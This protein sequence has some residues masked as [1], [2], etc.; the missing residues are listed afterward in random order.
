MG[1]INNSVLPWKQKPLKPT[2]TWLA[3]MDKRIDSSTETEI[4]NIGNKKCY[5]CTCSCRLPKNLRTPK[6]AL[7]KCNDDQ[8]GKLKES[9]ELVVEAKGLQRKKTN[10]KLKKTVVK[11]SIDKSN[12][13]TLDSTI[14][15]ST[16]PN[17]VS[18]DPVPET[19]LSDTKTPVFSQPLTDRSAVV[20]EICNLPKPSL[21][22]AHHEK[23]DSLFAF[24]LKCLCEKLVDI[25][26]NQ[27]NKIL[28]KIVI[29]LFGK[30][31]HIIKSID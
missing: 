27:Y 9:K 1:E 10:K 26:Q 18:T 31:E 17:N 8:S 16:N 22:N 4:S 30:H 23:G 24:T 14:P 5:S 25:P 2:F 28:H 29:Y 13:K 12:L 15:Q 20:Y 19:E 6:S 21:T 3:N 7:V 11:K